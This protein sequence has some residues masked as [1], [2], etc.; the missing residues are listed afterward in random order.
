MRLTTEQLAQ[1]LTREMKPLYTVYGEETLL[2]LEACDRIRAKARAIGYGERELLTVDSGFKWSQLGMA[3]QSQSLFS[4]N[5]LLE[6]RIPKRRG[7]PLV[8]P[9]MIDAGWRSRAA[10]APQPSS[11]GKQALVLVPSTG[12]PRDLP[13]FAA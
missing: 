3:S 10:R 13:R 5:K 1:Q 4:P 8:D 2:A 6:L 7:P 9:V 11:A 12:S